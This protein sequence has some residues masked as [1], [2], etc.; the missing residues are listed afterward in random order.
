MK[1]RLSPFLFIIIVAVLS[2]G[3]V[4]VVFVTRQVEK[5]TDMAVVE[6]TTVSYNANGIV[7]GNT[8]ENT[9][10]AADV[11]IKST[12]N[13]NV[14]V[15]TGHNDTNVNS[16]SAVNVNLEEDTSNWLTYINQD[17][18]YSIKY[19]SDWIVQPERATSGFYR[20]ADDVPQLILYD[21]NNLLLDY[22]YY[23]GC[24]LTI[25][26]NTA[27]E[28]VLEWLEISSLYTTRGEGIFA[29]DKRLKK[30][31][32]IA[33]VEVEELGPNFSKGVSFFFRSGDKIIRYGYLIGGDVDLRNK[34]ERYTQ[35]CTSV[36]N[37]LRLIHQ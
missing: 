3:V 5:K 21:P 30:I 22:E 34:F 16:K 14:E 15:E 12:G 1:K 31:N 4:I 35:L 18:G 25:F 29:S 2:M 10:A 37:T 36:M 8:V 6:N 32:N 28:D 17:Y 9:N 20:V 33:G 23:D 11:N 24:T 26:Q 27:G 13:S 7:N 19:P